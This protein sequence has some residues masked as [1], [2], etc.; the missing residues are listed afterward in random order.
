[1]TETQ[2]FEDAVRGIHQVLEEAEHRLCELG[3]DLQ[4]LVGL[5]GDVEIVRRSR[6]GTTERPKTVVARLQGC[7][8]VLWRGDVPA[9]L[10]SLSPRPER[11]RPVAPLRPAAETRED[12]A[13]ET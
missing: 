13:E 7:D 8:P 3:A 5:D 2:S 4:F 6:T 10:Q 12:L 11:P 9:W 1:M